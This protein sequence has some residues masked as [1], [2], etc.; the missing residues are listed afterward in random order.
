LQL[1]VLLL[2]SPLFVNKYRLPGTV[3][4]TRAAAAAAA[5]AAVTVLLVEVLALVMLLLRGTAVRALDN[6]HISNVLGKPMMLFMLV[7]RQSQ[8]MFIHTLMSM[9]SYNTACSVT[10]YCTCTIAPF[11]ITRI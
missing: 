4:G 10:T 9:L 2:L 1:Q 8:Q 6:A 11:E 3:I 5:A 7:L